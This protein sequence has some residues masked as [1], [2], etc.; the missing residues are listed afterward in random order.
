MKK[1]LLF[2]VLT[3]AA[4]LAFVP[5]ARTQ[6]L[7]AV[8]RGMMSSGIVTVNAKTPLT[9]GTNYTMSNPA[10]APSGVASATSGSCTTGGNSPYRFYTAWAN[11][12][13]ITN[14]SP[15]SANVNGT[16][17]KRVVVTRTETVP[18][19]AMGWLVYWSGTTDS[20]AVKRLCSAGSADSVLV[21]SGTS[22]YDCA[23]GATGTVHGGTNQ[24]GIK[25]LTSI[26][27]LAN[28]VIG[29]GTVG[30]T[31]GSATEDTR[32]LDLSGATPRWSADSGANY[33]LFMVRPTKLVTICASGCD[34]TTP[35]LACATETSTA[36]NPITYLVMPGVI[37]QSGTT[38][39]C[40][41]EDSA[42]FAG[43]G[44]GVSV[45]DCG[46]VNCLSLGESLNISVQGLTI[47]GRRSIDWS[48]LGTGGG[49]SHIHDNT[50]I[51]NNDGSTGED[52]IL[53][54][55]G[56]GAAAANSQLHL[57]DNRCGYVT[58]GFT[59]L[60][61]NNTAV[62]SRDNYFYHVTA[63]Y[64]SRASGWSLFAIPCI[65][66]S[67]G[68]VFNLDSTP[69]TA[70]S[71]AGVGNNAYLF[72]GGS[73]TSCTTPTS[74]SI[75]AASVYINDKTANGTNADATAIRVVST[76]TEAALI[77]VSGSS[78]SVN[79]PNDSGNGNSRGIEV[80]NATTVVPLY[81][82]RIRTT[83]GQVATRLDLDGNVVGSILV[84]PDSDWLTD[85]GKLT[86]D[87]SRN[88]L[89]TAPTSCTANKDKYIDTSGALCFC[90]ATDTWTNISGAGSC[91]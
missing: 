25:S 35:A 77:N 80:T 37:S 26:N 9:I 47:K 70:H 89:A 63:P 22:T 81:G 65:F 76:A 83:G 32:R 11:L 49:L 27:T 75:R 42:T 29:M 69:S 90:T 50:F 66:H 4:V 2:L 51:S 18:S 52:C 86:G 19:G 56:G 91:V 85:D 8:T 16:F 10:I 62:F 78:L 40:A 57:Y 55:S 58:D 34:Y 88:P 28:N 24:T 20:H 46:T 21:A 17:L 45:I 30:A 60:E 31:I 54:G 7:N 48:L 79:M 73:T 59:I 72:D 1:A 87:R 41:A 38:Q 64:S 84:G 15:A 39:T 5:P 12:S 33:G 53:Y 3:I 36:A 61:D 82:T 71:G 43:Y 14:L 44:A 68:D 13:G 23:C 74:L 6:I 67:V